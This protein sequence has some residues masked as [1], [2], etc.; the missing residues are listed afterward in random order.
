MQPDVEQ[1]IQVTFQHLDAVLKRAMELSPVKDCHQLWELLPESSAA[2]RQMMLAELVKLDMSIAADHDIAREL[3]FYSHVLELVYPNG[4]LPLDLVLEEIRSR[5]RRGDTVSIGEFKVR[6]PH[7]ASV[8][9]DVITRVASTAAL[10]GAMLKLERAPVFAEGS[11]ID[12]FTILRSLG[13]GGFAN[14]YL[15]RQ[16]SIQRLVALKVSHRGSDE[17]IALSQLDHPNIVRVYDQ[18]AVTDPPMILLYMQYIPV[19]PWP[20]SFAPQRPPRQKRSTEARSCKRWIAH[21]WPQ[22]NN[23]RNA[24]GCAIA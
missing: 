22:I 2:A 12:D 18:R 4:R 17:P 11:H 16:N 6:F 14:V 20:I 8:L 23:P 15:A 1:T 19:V 21:L 9:D 7:L 5:R 10:P 13:Q 3:S 24:V